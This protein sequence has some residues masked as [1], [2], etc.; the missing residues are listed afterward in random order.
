MAISEQTPARAFGNFLDMIQKVESMDGYNPNSTHLM[1][2]EM[3][4]LHAEGTA[5]LD[6]YQS[7]KAIML[8][9]KKERVESVGVVKET[10]RRVVSLL[11]ACGAS[12]SKIEQAMAIYRLIHGYKAPGSSKPAEITTEPADDE[13]KKK[14]NKQG[15]QDSLV[16]NFQ[17]LIQVIKT[18][19]LYNPNEADLKVAGLESRVNKFKADDLAVATAEAACDRAKDRLKKVYNTRTTGAEDVMRGM[20]LYV[21]AVFGPNSPE[22]KSVAKIIVPALRF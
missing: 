13:A 20:K 1:V 21:K 11:K 19:R 12:E 16:Q 7:L 4:K 3:N 9:G 10:S 8:A 6:A 18:E 2:P 17:N 22:Y 14:S 15:S 5:A